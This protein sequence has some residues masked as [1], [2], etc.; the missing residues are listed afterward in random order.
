MVLPIQLHR[1]TTYY[2]GVLSFGQ[3]TLHTDD[4]WLCA[5]IHLPVTCISM[6]SYNQRYFYSTLKTC[7]CWWIIRVNK[8]IFFVM[9][10][11]AY[12][13]YCNLGGLC[14]S[15]LACLV[16]ASQKNVNFLLD[17]LFDSPQDPPDN[18][19]KV[20]STIITFWLR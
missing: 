9:K 14:F 19:S 5:V 17:N 15:L 4:D 8:I 18:A 16:L 1:R 7:I 11:S 12:G 6:Y 3:K 10:K 13:E 20:N 2:V